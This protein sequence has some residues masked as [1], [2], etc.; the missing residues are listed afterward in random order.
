[1]SARITWAWGAAF[2]T[3]AGVAGLA[4]RFSVHG[5][6]PQPIYFRPDASLMDLYSTAFWANTTEAYAHW[7]SLY[8]PLSFAFLKVFSIHACYVCGDRGG[9]SCDWIPAAALGAFYI[10]NIALVFGSLRLVDRTTALPRAIIFSAGLP[11]LY[12]LE[13]GNLL[14]PAFTGIVLGLGGLLPGAAARWASMAWAINFKPYLLIAGLS[15]IAKW[16]WRWFLGVGVFGL[17]IYG[18]S[19]LFYGSGTINQIVRHES[20]YAAALGARHFEDLY[21]ATS[22]W[23]LIRLLRAAPPGLH[24]LDAPWS[25]IVAFGLEAALRVTQFAAA[26]CLL[27][28]VP[29]PGRVDARRFCA[30]CAALSLTA[31]TTGSAGYTQIFLFFL[32]LLEPRRGPPYAILIGC[33][34]LLCLPVDLTLIPVIHAPVFSF[35]GGRTVVADFG[36]S[37]GQLVRPAILLVIQVILTIVSARDLL[38]PGGA[39]VAVETLSR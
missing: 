25:L 1:M 28:S 34:Y 10:L 33:V 36:I 26:V 24:I 4:W 2:L 14:I 29:W 19:Y 20:T 22:Y 7:H 21:Y 35:F 38:R 16:D 30:L 32:V 18:A 13:R 11:M 6:L 3:L 39:G 15:R 23:P 17:A 5:Y 9:R 8:P 31:F 37:L 12:A 27:V